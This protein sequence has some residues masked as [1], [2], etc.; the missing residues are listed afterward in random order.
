MSQIPEGW[1][2]E[3]HEAAALT[4][5][6][7]PL[8]NVWLFPRVLMPLH[9]FEPRYRK[10]IEDSMDGPGRIVMGTIVEGHED[11]M[12]AAPPVHTVAGIGEILRHDK[13]DDGR[14]LIQLLGL[15]RVIVR[16]LETDEPYRRVAYEPLEEVAVSDD[17]DE[18]LRPQLL[19][20]IGQ[21]L[22]K[23][24]E[25]PDDVSLGMLADVLLLRL[26]LSHAELQDL[27][28]QNDPAERARGALAA[29]EIQPL[30]DRSELEDELE[31]DDEDDDLL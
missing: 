10:M 25:L 15:E 9:I 3:P 18:E 30:P 28:A 16:E 5:P 14:Y 12:P 27:Y 20:A 23:P 6:L 22:A 21:R 26:K 1:P 8:P 29:H 2:P 17:D 19:E 7:F 11:E 31:G 24:F 13:T 4:A